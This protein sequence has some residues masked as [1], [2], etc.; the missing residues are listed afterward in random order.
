MTAAKPKTVANPWTRGLVIAAI[1]IAGAFAFP[2]GMADWL[3]ERNAGGWLNG[4]LAVARTVESVSG[5][6]G[7]RQAGQ[8]LRHAFAAWVGADES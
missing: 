6:L 3:D 4:P 7:V 5:A 8:G 1:L 2:G